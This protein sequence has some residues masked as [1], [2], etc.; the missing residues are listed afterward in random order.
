ML[1]L[2]RLRATAC[3]LPPRSSTVQGRLTVLE[4]PAGRDAERARLI[5]QIADAGPG[6][7]F[8]VERQEGALVGHVIHIRRHVPPV[9]AEAHHA[10]SSTHL[11]GD[12]KVKGLGGCCGE[13]ARAWT[14]SCWTRA[15]DAVGT[16]E[17]EKRVLPAGRPI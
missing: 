10:I 15:S 14:L 7:T 9:A 16:D 17:T 5:R 12:L 6:P 11:E 2:P 4:V 13:R 8:A 3:A 1:A